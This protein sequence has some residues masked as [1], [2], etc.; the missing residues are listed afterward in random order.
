[1]EMETKTIN[2]IILTGEETEILQAAA[3]LLSD[4]AKKIENTNIVV[5]FDCQ[6]DFNLTSTIADCGATIMEHIEL[7]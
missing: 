5:D 7:L 3:S 4:I 1:M 2:K 6:E